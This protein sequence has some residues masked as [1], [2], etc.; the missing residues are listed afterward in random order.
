M[1]TAAVQEQI[2]LRVHHPAHRD[3]R[4]GTFPFDKI[5]TTIPFARIND[6]VAAQARGEAVK[7]VLVPADPGPRAKERT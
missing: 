6:A 3:Y 4:A 7:V 2:G 5:I 1:V